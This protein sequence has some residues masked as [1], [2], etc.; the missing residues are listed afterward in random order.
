[1]IKKHAVAIG[2]NKHLYQKHASCFR[3]SLL[4]DIAFFVQQ[5]H[6]VFGSLKFR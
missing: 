6:V 4:V 1:M 5:T 3:Q 2:I